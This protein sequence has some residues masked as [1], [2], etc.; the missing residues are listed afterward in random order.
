MFLHDFCF[1]L[2]PFKYNLPFDKRPLSSIR[3][4][5]YS[6]YTSSRY[7]T[8]GI[9]MIRCFPWRTVKLWATLTALPSLITLFSGLDSF[10]VSVAFEVDWL[11][12]GTD[13]TWVVVAAG[14][15]FC[16]TANSTD[17]Y[18]LKKKKC[19][20]V[21]FMIVCLVS[22]GW[23]WTRL[24][25]FFFGCWLVTGLCFICVVVTAGIAVAAVVIGWISFVVCCWTWNF[26]ICCWG[27][28]AIGMRNCSPL[29]LVMNRMGWACWCACWCCA[30]SCFAVAFVNWACA[31]VNGEII[32]VNWGSSLCTCWMWTPD[33]VWIAI[34][35]FPAGSNGCCVDTITCCCCCGLTCFTCGTNSLPTFTPIFMSTAFFG[36]FEPGAISGC[37]ANLFD[38]ITLDVIILEP[39]GLD[40]FAVDFGYSLRTG[41]L[42]SLITLAFGLLTIVWRCVWVTILLGWIT[43]GRTTL[44][45]VLL[46]SW[47]AT[48]S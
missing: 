21:F 37:E 19:L 22:L 4:S 20:P 41:G 6:A 3:L 40:T 30:F 18:S 27:A 46:F 2:C 10:F 39:I 12:V 26:W 38:C 1:N 7:S 45:S 14:F 42:F 48:I 32:R 15:V 34:A 13:A 25:L 9:G 44:T 17:N 31:V 36:L 11:K 29:S 35:W 5:R 23:W 33:V 47:S 8:C 16:V 43:F 28:V 24:G